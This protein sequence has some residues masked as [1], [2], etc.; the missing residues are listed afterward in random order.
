MIL[1]SGFDFLN[2]KVTKHTKKNLTAENALRA[3]FLAM[4]IGITATYIYDRNN[5]IPEN[6]TGVRTA[7]APLL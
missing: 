4:A 1:C 7:P 3:T 5:E 2:T 6:N